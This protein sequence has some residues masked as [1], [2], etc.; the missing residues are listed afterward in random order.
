MSE[1]QVTVQAIDRH[2]TFMEVLLIKQM[3]VQMDGKRHIIVVPQETIV[4]VDNI[5]RHVYCGGGS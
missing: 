2:N 3:Y 4:E 5:T 1:H